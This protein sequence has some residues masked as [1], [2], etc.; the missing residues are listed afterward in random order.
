MKLRFKQQQFQADAASAVC[1]VFTGQPRAE[2]RFIIEQGNL[3]G[4]LM[5]QSGWL[6]API[7]LS[8]SQLLANIQKVQIRNGLKPSAD[9]EICP[10]SKINLTVE[11]ETGTGK[12]YVYL[13]TIHELHKAYNWL[14]F[15]IVVPSIAIR[16]GVYKTLQITEE[17]FAELYGKKI[18][19]FIYK[20]SNP[21]EIH[22]FVQDN[23]INVMIINAQAFNARSEDA[24]RI[25][26]EQD[27]FGSARPVDAIAAVNP[28]LIID[29]PQSVSGPATSAALMDFNPLFILRYSATPE[30]LYN[31]V[32]RLDAQDAYNQ[33]LVKKIIVSSV[34]Q[35]GLAG[36]AG[37]LYLD[38]IRITGGNPVA[39]L[40]YEQKGKNGIIR[41]RRLLREGDNLYRL[42]GELE[43]YRNDFIVSRIDGIANTIEFANGVTLEAGEVAGDSS[44]EQLRRLQIR[45]TIQAHLEREERNFRH[46]IKTLS[47]FFIDRVCRYRV[48]DQTGAALPGEYA[49]ILEEEYNQLVKE[50]LAQPGLL[51]EYHDWL[52]KQEAARAHAGYFSID[53]KSKQ[54]IDSPTKRSEAL[55]DDVDAFDLIMRNRERLLDLNEP[56]RFIFSHSALQEGWDN[57]NV[58]QI[59]TLKQSSSR[60]RK[61]QE[62]GRGMRL[63]VNSEGQRI[64]GDLAGKLASEINVL[65][66][67]P[68]AAY[69]DFAVALQTE[70]S[71]DISSRP[72]KVKTDFFRGEI[73]GKG[74][75]TITV[76]DIFSEKIH[77]DLVINRYLD[78]GKLTRK[79]YEDRENGCLAFSRELEPYR[80]EIIKKL[81]TVFNEE[82]LK[83]KNG[84]AATVRLKLDPEKWNSDTFNN[85]WARISPLTEYSAH[86]NEAELIA[87]SIATVNAKLEVQR[88]HF[89]LEAGVMDEIESRQQLLEGKAF[90][91]YADKPQEL[92]APKR[93]EVKIDLL[94]RVAENARITRRSAAEILK[95]LT[96]AKFSQYAENPEDFILKVSRIIN[97][98]KARLLL[99][100]IAYSKTGA[101]YDKMMLK[102]AEKSDRPAASS[103]AA[104]KH[105]FDYVICDSETER[106]FAE[107]LDLPEND[108]EMFIK[109]PA[110]FKIPTPFEDYNP[111]WAIAFRKGG[112]R[113]IFFVA[114]TKGSTDEMQLRGKEK[115][116]IECARK[117]FEALAS[118]DTEYVVVSDYND[119]M[120]KTREQ[121]GN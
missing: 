18:R 45:A 76:T 22:T 48:Y 21:Q 54:A 9:L 6:N 2:R 28:I 3:P 115:T 72:K 120:N 92:A 41:K 19:F 49:D 64:D 102:N 65:T 110:E 29:E 86:L 32:Y 114:E 53:K 8:D 108:I 93:S 1:D 24:R 73:F 81:D 112:N 27:D 30:R 37:Y 59:C 57:P 67:I 100:N 13:K 109:L 20:A 38:Q 106:K 69:K 51:P 31:L 88:I 111:D 103:L 74:S 90:R 12:T 95:G 113:K 43:Q 11:M 121:G 33:R 77:Q 14:K 25:R 55:S 89:T 71:E 50:K 26:V 82:A 105:L 46:G 118:P 5:P 36:E 97:E 84:R 91:Q 99:K 78:L 56:V 104:E 44:E 23:G 87:E 17:H 98:V 47:L 40:E 34:R 10:A 80:E 60:T 42:S 58:F 63:C 119:L 39:E 94:G 101:S 83:P 75:E 70:Y 16:E 96:K 107:K 68:S 116:K 7:E 4:Q 35:T 66:V 79:Y 52:A 117:H 61:R 85:L 62:I 15:I